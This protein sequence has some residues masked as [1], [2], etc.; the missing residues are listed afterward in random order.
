MSDSKERKQPDAETTEAVP[1]SEEQMAGI[2]NQVAKS[3]KARELKIIASNVAKTLKPKDYLLIGKTLG[4]SPFFWICLVFSLG[5]VCFTA[6]KAVPHFVKEKAE[7]VFNQEITN[8][9][10]LQFQDARIS[11][12]MVSVAAK[13]TTNL[14]L[15]AIMP[16]IDKFKLSLSEK[17]TSKTAEFGSLTSGPALFMG[18]LSVEGTNPRTILQDPYRHIDKWAISIRGDDLLWEYSAKGS[19]WVPIVSLTPTGFALPS[20]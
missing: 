4:K 10:K 17:L 1:L 13:E 2:A 20:K 14:M 15:H 3:L 11:N 5:T 16:E 18:G 8:Q 7:T 19:N 12:I 9:I 6:W